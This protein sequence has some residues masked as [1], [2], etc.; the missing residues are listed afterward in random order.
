MKVLLIFPPLWAA[1]R[2]YLS[3]PSLTAF[4]RNRNIDAVQKDFNIEAYDLL[5]S[6]SYL[7]DTGERLRAKFK[8]L[9]SKNMLAPGIEQQLYY[10][11]FKAKSNI[12]YITG[13]VENAKSTLRSKDS[14]YDLAAYLNARNILV[15]AQTLISVDCLPAGGDLVSPVNMQMKRTFPEIKTLAQ[16][17]DENPFIGLYER[18]L[19][20]YITDTKPDIVGISISG[21]RQLVPGLTLSRLIKLKNPQVHVT[22]GGYTVTQLSQVLS[23]HK[24][25][26]TDFFDSAILFQ[27]ERPLF[28]LVECIAGDR[29]LETVPNLV[30][31]EHG[32]IHFNAVSAAEDIN[33]LPT[34]CF[35]GLPLN[36]YLSPESVLPILS[37]RGCYWGKCAFCSHNES[38]RW[39]YQKR[40][41]GKVVDDMQTL[42][43]KHGVR[44]FAFSD[45]AIS[46]SGMK[47]ITDE[48]IG[49]QLEVRCSTNI[50]LERQFTPELCSQ[51]YRAGFRVLHLGLE[52]GCDRVLEHMQKGTTR[53]TAREV[54]QNTY[55]AGLWNHVYVFFGFPTET[56]IEAR[57]TAEFLISNREYIQSFG[58]TNFILN[59]GSA[60]MNDPDRF[61]ITSVDAD[62][63]GDF[64][65]DFAYTV[66]SGLSSEQARQL[67]SSYREKITGEFKYPQRLKLYYE[68]ILLYL[69]HYH[70]SDPALKIMADKVTAGAPANSQFTRKSIPALKPH[71]SF[72]P[73]RFDII[74]IIMNKISKT[75]TAAAYP[76]QTCV[77]SDP[78]S[79]K[80]ISISS[81]EMEILARCNE[82]NNIK[83][84]AL[85]LSKKYGAP[86]SKAEETCIDSLKYLSDQGYISFHQEHVK[87]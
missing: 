44:H 18:Y 70:D 46:P 19:L 5:L 80:L 83:Q 85:K 67:A 22:I 42:S 43:E 57:Q 56:E 4:L 10:S 81:L 7:K 68:D 2:P 79:G 25:L 77:L 66:S 47:K 74:D 61:G 52:S 54:L 48:I 53:Q 73:L 6:E 17:K 35:D 30:Y 28:E 76:V 75:T 86:A 50:R 62:P 27:G 15:Q 49:R 39:S 9:D 45:E 21:E 33:T 87:F 13:Q 41:A 40:D 1:H 8:A 72:E 34:P 20:P 55:R 60:A 82:K 78:V 69:S 29:S 12:D 26:F 32:E 64:N 3:L 65:L 37:S 36:R 14:F 58:V 59:K 31:H 84:I 63:S 24:E 16:S 11:L 38:Y 71:V 51:M 23:G